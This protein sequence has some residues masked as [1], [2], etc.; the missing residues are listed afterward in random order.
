M[1]ATIDKRSVFARKNDFYPDLPQGYQISQSDQPIVGEGTIVIEI[2]PDKAGAFEEVRVGIERV[3]LERDPG[4]SPARP[5][6]EMS[7]VD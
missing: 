3:H 7:Y 1:K 6:P 5:A 4:K 2:G